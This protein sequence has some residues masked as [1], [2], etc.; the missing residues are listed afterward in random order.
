MHSIC[1]NWGD[2]TDFADEVEAIRERGAEVVVQAFHWGT[3][4]VLHDPEGNRIELKDALV[5]A[6]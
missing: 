2:I 3:V 1:S 4:G 6:T 5:A